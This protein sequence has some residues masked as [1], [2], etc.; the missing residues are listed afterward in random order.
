MV[1]LYMGNCP[2]LHTDY[3]CGEEKEGGGSGSGG[4]DGELWQFSKAMSS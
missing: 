2:L 1:A 3:R 4:M